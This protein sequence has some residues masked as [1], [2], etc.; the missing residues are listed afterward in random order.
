MRILT[1]PRNALVKQYQ[2]LLA[3]DGITLTFTEEA[4]RKIAQYAAQLG[5]G[6]R[7]LRTL[8]ETILEDVLFA[9]PTGATIEI[10]AATVE[11]RLR[12]LRAAG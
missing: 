8:L 12:P 6:A 4:L 5:T 1:E 7:A 2:Q 9:R 11:A 3:W 10:D